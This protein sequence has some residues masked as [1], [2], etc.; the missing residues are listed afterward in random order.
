MTPAQKAYEQNVIVPEQTITR[1]LNPPTTNTAT[2]SYSVAG[3]D[4]T[5]ETTGLITKSQ[6]V[7]G[8]WF[9]S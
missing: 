4:P 1:I 7:S 9:T 2:S 5:N 8:T 3:V 6:L